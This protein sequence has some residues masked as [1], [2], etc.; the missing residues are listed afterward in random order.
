VPVAPWQRA[1]LAAKIVFPWPASPCAVPDALLIVVALPADVGGGG[2]AVVVVVDD[3]CSPPFAQPAATSAAIVAA[4]ASTK[5]LN[6]MGVLSGPGPL[7][8]SFTRRRE[9]DLPAA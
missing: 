5:G 1:Q 7:N 9:F 4:A 6:C 2:A 3:D 8:D